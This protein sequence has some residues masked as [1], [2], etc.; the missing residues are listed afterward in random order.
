MGSIQSIVDDVT[1]DGGVI[2]VDSNIP[3]SNKPGPGTYET[4]YTVTDDAIPSNIV[5]IIE[6][7]EVT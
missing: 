4:T 5:V 6:T 2:V 3:P 1:N 7:I